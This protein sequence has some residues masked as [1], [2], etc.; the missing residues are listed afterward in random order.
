MLFFIFKF[1]SEYT[2]LFLLSRG[3]HFG[4]NDVFNEFNV[5]IVLIR[6]LIVFYAGLKSSCG[7]SVRRTFW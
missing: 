3:D 2:C 6:C 1:N 7:S 4:V 5:M